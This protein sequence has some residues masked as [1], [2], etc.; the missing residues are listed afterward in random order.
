MNLNLHANGASFIAHEREL[1]PRDIIIELT[2]M[3]PE[4][5]RAA[6]FARFREEIKDHEDY[7]RKIDWYFFVNM[8]DYLTTRRNSPSGQARAVQKN[9]EHDVVKDL[10]QQIVQLVL[11]DLMLPNGKVLREATGADCAKAGGWFAAIAKKVKPKQVVGAVLS[12]EQLQ[13]MR[14]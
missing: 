5:D 14:R 10:K 11:L 3:Y 6:L 8:H 13:A 7:Q 9:A 2:K 4:E 1:N 12:E